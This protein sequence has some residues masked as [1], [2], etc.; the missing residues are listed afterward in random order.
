MDKLVKYRQ[1][2]QQLIMKYAAIKSSNPMIEQLP[3]CDTIR[4]EY[5]LLSVGWEKDGKR[6]NSPIFHFRIK[7]GKVY[8]EEDNTDVEIVRQMEELGIESEDIVLAFYPPSHRKYTDYA[9]A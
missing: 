8:V 1:I 9:V 3:V 5:L 7:N 4:D 2:L 6:R